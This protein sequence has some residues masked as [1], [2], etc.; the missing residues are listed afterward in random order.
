[1]GVLDWC[2]YKPSIA[3]GLAY[4]TGTVFEIHD[5]AGKERAVAGGGRYDGLVE[6]FGGP[7][8]AASGIAM[9]DA[10]LR[11]ILE[12]RGLLEPTAMPWP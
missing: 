2:D 6:L 7:S 5:A 8:T 10:V 11:L 3:R 4:Y 12:D 1:M 9:G